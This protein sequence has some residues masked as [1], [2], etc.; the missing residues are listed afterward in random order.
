MAGGLDLVLNPGA[1]MSGP[2][3][4]KRPQPCDDRGRD[5]R[6]A[7]GS[8]RVLERAGGDRDGLKGDHRPLTAR[9]VRRAAIAVQRSVSGDR[10]RPQGS[11]TA[12]RIPKLQ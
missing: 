2:G 12:A 6:A 9:A 10:V 4:G 3:A 7:G 5:R 11:R 1:A 8:A